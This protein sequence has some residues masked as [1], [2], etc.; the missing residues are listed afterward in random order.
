MVAEIEVKKTARKAGRKAKEIVE[1]AKQAVAK[2]ET[3]I[4]IQSPMGGEISIE[5][6]KKKVPE[7]AEVYVRVDQNKLWWSTD[8][9][10]GDAD[11]W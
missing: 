2:P 5:E 11:I 3:K 6:I 9:E 10:N 4:I 7:G 8:T 1:D